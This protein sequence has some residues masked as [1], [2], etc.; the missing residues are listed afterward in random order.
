MISESSCTKGVLTLSTTSTVAVFLCNQCTNDIDT[1]IILKISML[2]YATISIPL[3][4]KKV[5]KNRVFLSFPDAAILGAINCI[6]VTNFCC[7]RLL[8]SIPDLDD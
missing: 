2:V 1:D 4:A 5:L 7:Y 8:A 3:L 6:V